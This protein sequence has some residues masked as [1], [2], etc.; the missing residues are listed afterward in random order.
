[1]ILAFALTFVMLL[2]SFAYLNVNKVSAVPVAVQGMT[3]NGVLNSDYYLLYP[4]LTKSF[5]IGFSKYG[6]LI[7]SSSS[8]SSIGVGMQY[9]GYNNVGTYDQSLKTS[10][11]PFANEMVPKNLWVNGWLVNITYR[12][13]IFESVG[14]GALAYRNVWAFALFS[15]G[16]TI[17]G[18]WNNFLP[19]PI[20]G[21][22]G[23]QCN[24]NA[25]TSN[26]QVL[27]NG[28]RSFVAVATTTIYDNQTVTAA[29]HTTTQTWPVAEVLIT[30]NFDKV[31]KDIVLYKDVKL[32]LNQ[33]NLEGLA[34]IQLSNRGEWDM[35]PNLKSYSY[36][37][38]AWGP[39]Q[40]GASYANVTGPS[41]NYEQ[42]VMKSVV[43]AFKGSTAMPAGNGWYGWKLSC[44]TLLNPFVS[45][46]E[47]VFVNGS[48]QLPSVDS[49]GTYAM[50]LNTTTGSMKGQEWLTF[51]QSF[52]TA[53]SA[54]TFVIEYKNYIDESY[55]YG[56]PCEYTLAQIIEAGSTSG[57][58]GQYVGFA[59]FWPVLSAYTPDGWGKRL[60]SIVNIT[61]QYAVGAQPN[62]AF[63]IGQWD[64]VLGAG[65]LGGPYP[66]FRGVEEY[67]LTDYHDA[68]HPAMTYPYN[69]SYTEAKYPDGWFTTAPIVDREIQYMLDAVFDP[70]NLYTAV[71]QSTNRCE[72]LYNVTADDVAAAS[73]PYY[74]DLAINLTVPWSKFVY[75]Y[76]WDQ[77]ASF[78][79]RV[80]W[81]GTLQYPLPDI[82]TGFAR[83]VYS[84]TNGTYWIDGAEYETAFYWVY[85]VIPYL[86]VP[87]AG[88]IIQISFSI[89]DKDFEAGGSYEWGIVGRD[90]QTIDSAGL[91]MV[92]AI[93]KDKHVEYNL[94]GADM[95]STS[96]ANMMPYIMS[97]MVKGGTTRTCYMDTLGR[98][99]LRSYYCPTATTAKS[100]GELDWEWYYNT[101]WYWMDSF[102]NEEE[103]WM[104]DG[105]Y[106]NATAIASSNIVV[107]GG[108]FANLAAY[109]ANDFT[110]ANFNT[111]TGKITAWPCWSKNSYASNNTFGYAVV[112]TFLDENGT[113]MFL[114]WG[115][116]GRDTFWA[117]RWLQIDGAYEMQE[118]RSI[119]LPAAAVEAGVPPPSTIP[120]F[121][122]VTS[123]VVQ[124]D[125][126]VSQ[127]NP[128]FSV[129]ECLGTI[130]ETL[131]SGVKG[132]IHPDP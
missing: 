20:L 15:D 43:D 40:Y 62:V 60:S 91:S 72:I 66:Q 30:I 24:H 51:P 29:G 56:M 101:P 63:V 71:E 25:T 5:D 35:G 69:C 87:K 97:L 99:A 48:Y 2:G 12:C 57:M 59:A 81:Q 130:S 3:V 18:N 77:Y 93:L 23:R 121:T 120:A 13:P 119:L 73:A 125:Y 19:T 7:N 76:T 117:S 39:C 37:Y 107:E 32:L 102:E 50:W 10:I 124:I 17:G 94:A 89:G 45:N 118:W 88:T 28:P 34:D 16:F 33:K 11:D 53:H 75:A 109:Y 116:Y 110:S 22:G 68:T 126:K 58:P 55:E 115:Y 67:G 122:G 64:T 4:F 108:Y 70:F 82:E 131:V 9:P 84:Y 79:E 128:T 6:E 46:A 38:P 106:Y 90:A 86:Y 1:M 129:V 104:G 54:S 65:P 98:T 52:I 112:S 85:V 83:S 92:A 61:E 44:P 132:G 47:S 14:S 114:V 21:A 31:T 80:V 78:G 113:V 95:N 74:E 26:L 96:N 123:V 36:F 8:P 42:Y 100:Y 27:E 103:T 49:G 111:M 105:A 127:T 41:G